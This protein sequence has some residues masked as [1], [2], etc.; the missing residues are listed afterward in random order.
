MRRFIFKAC[1]FIMSLSLFAPGAVAYYAGDAS[2]GRPG[3]YLLS[4]SADA[5]QA[6]VGGSGS[7]F[8]GRLSGI[9]LNPASLCYLKK[10][11]LTVLISSDVG[12]IFL[13]TADFMIS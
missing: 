5:A 9:Y 3:D 11:E 8:R 7:A 10:N 13:S 12:F 4:L 1:V 2:G 6:A